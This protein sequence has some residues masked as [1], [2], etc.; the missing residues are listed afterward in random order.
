MSDDRS[1][2]VSSL[3]NADW[4]R[5]LEVGKQPFR[6]RRF[7]DNFSPRFATVVLVRLAQGAFQRRWYGT[8]KL[9]SLLNFLLFGIEVPPRLSIGPGLVI[10]HSQGTVLGARVIGD[11]VTIFHQVTLGARE[12]DFEFDPLL[13][14]YVGDG[15]T[16]SVGSKVLGPVSIGNGAVI[17]ANA[18]VLADVPSGSLAVGVPAHIVEK[19]PRAVAG[20][21]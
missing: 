18:V 17:G 19:V 11:N 14:P 9:M 12:A 16:L 20:A 5:L 15:V 13:R 2:T 21:E 10:P 7:V 1:K 6:R 8:A 4:A 3:L